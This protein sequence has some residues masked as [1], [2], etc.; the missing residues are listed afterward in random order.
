MNDQAIIDEIAGKEVVYKIP[1]MDKVVPQ[2]DVV[3]FQSEEESLVMDIYH[4]ADQKTK[5]ET[6][7]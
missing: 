2:E 6:L 4:P 1:G 3:Y 5:E 7:Q